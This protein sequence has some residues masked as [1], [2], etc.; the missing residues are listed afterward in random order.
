[1]LRQKQQRRRWRRRQDLRMTNYDTEF[2][3]LCTCLTLQWNTKMR[4]K[5]TKNTHD[6][7][8][9]T[10]HS[11]LA[12][13]ANE[14]LQICMPYFFCFALFFVMPPGLLLFVGNTHISIFYCWFSVFGR[15][16]NIHRDR[17]VCVLFFLSVFRSL[18]Y[19][20]YFRLNECTCEC[21]FPFVHFMLLIMSSLLSVAVLLLL[22]L[23]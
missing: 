18:Y 8:K 11:P 14:D 19:L 20:S 13:A 10:I 4:E 12:S 9:H 7:L 6:W 16:Q 17:F 22:L 2:H 5:K 1:M 3:L 23:L 15:Q 21:N